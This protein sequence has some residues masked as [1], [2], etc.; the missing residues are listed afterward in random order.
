MALDMGLPLYAKPDSA[1]ICF[2][3][4]NDYR[5]FL[6]DRIERR[7]GAIVDQGGTVVGEHEGVA[8]Y[9][10]GQR[11]RLGAFGGKRFVT[12]IDPE[13]NVITIGEDEDLLASG[14]W[15][16]K[17]SWI[18]GEPPSSEFQATVKVRYKSTPAPALIRVHE[19]E[20]EVELTQPLRAVTP[21]QAAV[22]YDGSR[23]LGG[24]IIARTVRRQQTADIL[25][26]G[27]A[28]PD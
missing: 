24:G 9:T 18:D 25:R 13:L 2:V 12:S 19:H 10:I 16:D 14:L 7:P 15:A 1:E 22:F 6:E 11:K 26:A 28:A 5:A 27:V 17:P 4:G 21:G 8:G 20:I 3:P 23:V